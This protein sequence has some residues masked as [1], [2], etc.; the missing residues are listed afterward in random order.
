MSSKEMG[1]VGGAGER[2][3][4]IKWLVKAFFDLVPHFRY[5]KSVASFVFGIS[6]VLLEMDG[7]Q[8]SFLTFFHMIH[9]T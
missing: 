6:F 2:W 9:S 5:W 7:F 4:I 3:S 1:L 8:K